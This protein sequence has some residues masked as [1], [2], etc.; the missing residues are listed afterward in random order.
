MKKKIGLGVLALL[1]MA[2]SV[3]ALNANV[4]GSWATYG[5]GIVSKEVES[6]NEN[7]TVIAN[8]LYEAD[9]SSNS[10]SDTT[11]TGVG[12]FG[13]EGVTY[14]FD[15]YED[16]EKTYNSKLVR[17]PDATGADLILREVTW[18]S[19]WIG[20]G[21][22]VYAVNY[23]GTGEDKLIAYA[24]N[25][26]AY[27]RAESAGEVLPQ[28]EGSNVSFET[29]EGNADLYDTLVNFS[30]EFEYCS[31]IKLVD[32]TEDLK[33]LGGSGQNS[34]DGYDLDAVYG[35]KVLYA[36]V[37][38]ITYKEET[39]VGIGEVNVNCSDALANNVMKVNVSELID[40]DKTFDIIIDGNYKIGTGRI[41]LEE[42]VVKVDYAIYSYYE[43][44]EID[45]A[46][47]NISKKLGCSKKEDVTIED[48]YAYIS[49]NLKVSVSE[50]LYD[51]FEEIDAITTICEEIE[52]PEDDDTC[53]KEHSCD[54]KHKCNNEHKCNK[55]HKCDKEHKRDKE[56]MCDNKDKCNKDCSNKD[57]NKEHAN[58]FGDKIKDKIEH[59]KKE[60]HKVVKNCTKKVTKTYH[61]VKVNVCKLFSQ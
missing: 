20:E 13:E 6:G 19:S 11:F 41:Y 51:Y 43:I 3:S 18:G 9:A 33:Y 56:H 4:V 37:G 57:N 27:T 52:V 23:N 54:K 28:V 40:G 55:D 50:Y 42:D 60:C 8:S 36:P 29:V 45:N 7:R 10:G 25:K 39:A 2:P 1:A 21:V 48:E 12:Y 26:V 34:N 47:I 14:Y 53:N 24:Y 15:K 5:E 35:Y 22:E 32:I 38:D 17:N 30:D 58:N 49:L 44:E 59:T 46:V 16:G 61:K 31:A